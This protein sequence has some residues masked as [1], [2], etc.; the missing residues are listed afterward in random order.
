MTF[1]RLSNILDYIYKG[2]IMEEKKIE[3][4]FNIIKNEEL[5]KFDKQLRNIVIEASEKAYAPYSKLRVGAAIMFETGCYIKGNNQENA[6]FPSGLC[7]ERV[8]LF[9]ALSEFSTVK[10]KSLG[11]MAVKN[12]KIQPSISPC[13]ACCQVLLEA[14]QRNEQDIRVLLFGRDKTIIVPTAKCL[15][16]F[17]F[18]KRFF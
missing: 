13:G 18:G 14:E 6:A 10:I 5:T 4:V 12:D 16:P 11:I 3:F 15:L 7:A 2:K 9:S 17:Y 1:I 8:V